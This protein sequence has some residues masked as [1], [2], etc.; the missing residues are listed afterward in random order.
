MNEYY[1]QFYAWYFLHEIKILYLNKYNIIIKKIYCLIKLMNEKP[2]WCTIYFA[3]NEIVEHVYAIQDIYIFKPFD[4]FIYVYTCVYD[5]R[6][7]RLNNNQQARM[8][9]Q[10]NDG[11][12]VWARCTGANSLLFFFFFRLD[13]I[14]THGTH[15]FIAA[16]TI[17]VY[18]Y[19]QKMLIP[20]LAHTYLRVSIG[21]KKKKFF[22]DSLK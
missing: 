13:F 8:G 16:M 6:Q 2:L 19:V 3:I 4:V 15:V 18:M 21:I 14:G 11:G 5:F 22:F 10:W 20:A 9:K 12:W 7:W 1:F 17:C